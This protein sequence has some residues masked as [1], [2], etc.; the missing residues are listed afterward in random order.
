MRHD[1]EP[2]HYSTGEILRIGAL[3]LR[4][5]VRGGP[6]A[7][8]DRRVAAIQAAAVERE[9]AQQAARAARRRS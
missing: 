9:A 3:V 6:T 2:Q 7:Q 1:H 4:A 5:A 8:L